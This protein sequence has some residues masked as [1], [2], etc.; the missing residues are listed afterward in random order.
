MNTSLRHLQGSTTRPGARLGGRLAAGSVIRVRL[1]TVVTITLL[2][3]VSVS[4]QT[5]VKL[6]DGFVNEPYTTFSFADTVKG[7]GA[8]AQWAVTTGALPSGLTLTQSGDLSGT[9]TAAQTSKFEVQATVGGVET[10]KTK[11]IL[12]VRP[13]GFDAAQVNSTGV[14]V[15]SV[16]SGPAPTICQP[17][18][19]SFVLASSTA[20]E[21]TIGL[22]ED[23][24]PATLAAL[25]PNTLAI[26]DADQLIQNTLGNTPAGTA[27]FVFKKGDYIIIRILK[28]GA[29]KEAGK[30]DPDKKL[31]ALY[32]LVGS[33]AGGTL[34]WEA[35]M[36]PD[37]KENFDTRIFG[38]RRVAVL[39]LHLQTPRTWDIKYK[40]NINQR[41]PQPIQDVLQLAAFVGGTGATD[42]ECVPSPTRNIWGGRMLLVR[43]RASDMIVKLNTV[44]ANEDGKQIS[45]SKED[46]KQYLNEGRYHWDVSVGM[47]VKSIKQLEFSS[48]NGIVTAKKKEKQNA[49]GF[50]NLFPRAVDLNGKS[51]LTSPHFVL[52]VPISGKPLDRP[53][54]GVGTGLYTKQ[55]KMNFF[56]GIVFN[57]VQEPRTL[58]AGQSA[59]TGQLENDLQ[60]RRVRKFVFG[61]NFPVRQFIEAV[62]A[63]K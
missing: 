52:G 51:Y 19:S 26:L 16:D 13:A 59:T 9:P 39:V 50:L 25:N 22:T 6:N 8:G 23:A 38:S 57:K 45:Q 41:V 49:Y 29:V 2:G 14:T 60:T 3:L 32:E 30:A 7:E 5:T 43:H 61:I 18:A 46:S 44:T 28:W 10:F 58:A 15:T 53:V 34:K 40:V 42:D 12:R 55:F 63:A 48:E 11:V 1:L 47:P 36:N 33:G 21:E 4:A 24:N 27:P 20:E 54:V 56:A 17:P 62:K 37:D 35:R 31:D